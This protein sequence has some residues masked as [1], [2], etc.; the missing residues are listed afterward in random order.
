MAFKRK[1]KREASYEDIE[2]LFRDRRNRKVQGLLSHQS[3]IL[4]RYEKEVIDKP[5]VAIELPTGSGKTLVGLLI[6][7]FRRITRQERILYL[8]PTRQLVRQV[9]EQSDRKYGISAK[10]FI[11]K[12]RDYN[13]VDKS[14][15]E[16]GE[17][18]AVAPYGA[19]FNTNP[20]FKNPQ[21][22]VLDD[23]HASE[24]YI[25]S[26]W[27]LN[28]NRNDNRL[29]FELLQIFN[30]H[31]PDLSLDRFQ[32]DSFDR[33]VEK[34]PTATLI[35]VS[36]EVRDFLNENLTKDNGDLYYCWLFL[37]DH[38]NAC[39]VYVSY[40]EILIRPY[41]PPSLTHQP[42]ANATQRVFMSATLGMGGDLERM[43]GIK[44]FSR[45]PIPDGWD[46]QGIGRRY[47]VFPELS[48]PE[49]EIESLTKSM[50]QQAG[51]ALILVP[52][53]QQIEKYETLFKDISLYKAADIERSK[54]NFVSQDKGV[55]VLANRYD[56]IDFLD[57]DCR[58]L[59]IEG[60]PKAGNLQ[61]L[62]LTT[63]MVAGNLFKDRIRTRIIQAFGRCT[64]SATDYAAI[65]VIGDDFHDWL[66]HPEKRSL[67][68]P[69]LQGEL[70]FGVEQ[71][72]KVS[73][74][75]HIDN[76]NT[77]L[78][79]EDDWDEV[80]V[81]I[82]EYR[83]EVEQQPMPGQDQLLE[84]AALEVDYTYAVWNSDY[85]K[86]L[87]LAQN[88]ASGL[89]GEGLKGL[90]GLWYYLA[91][92]SAE[93]ASRKLG[94]QEVFMQNAADLYRRASLCLPALDWIRPLSARTVD[95]SSVT[96]T[97]DEYLL[98]TNIEH[99]DLFF[100]NKSFASPQ[101]FERVAKFILDGLDTADSDK[102]E[103][104]HRLLGEMLGFE[105]GN[106]D[107]DAAPDPW[108]ISGKRLCLV[109]EDKSDSKPDGAIPVKHTRQAASHP[110]WIK[111][112]IKLSP[113]AEIFV[114]MIT[115]QSKI[116]HEVPTYS[117]DVC[118]WHIDDFREWARHVI[119]VLRN[120][121]S[122][123]TGAGQSEW[124]ELVKE[125]LL[126]HKLDPISIMQ[127]T[128]QN[129]LKDLDFESSNKS[130]SS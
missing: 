111:K 20:F 49:K 127:K 122:K 96:V 117:K 79:H 4:R 113:N 67:F 82:R 102:F 105:S 60:L 77:F 15:Y 70:M 52:R 68:H 36:R 32:N 14:E 98:H 56:G 27:S 57:S 18:I 119:E 126:E 1:K 53:D 7:E 13:T 45:L 62:F 107:A 39:H 99:I 72:K 10:P 108:W 123:F 118:W 37:K 38:L 43:T 11:G 28:I 83:D 23:A 61:E 25:A 93:L 76:L 63:R 30:L 6:A 101:R 8:C 74:E 2:A 17:I 86:A 51:R 29:Y 125:Q 124:R 54:D 69:E 5:D 128:R 50:A 31:D 42:F 48:L 114:T 80:D 41:I 64:R 78:E 71:S 34:I 85:E 104:A 16:T 58:L 73:S 24:N 26:K 95:N 65:V 94:K 19:L 12:V 89:S 3:D 97:E 59:I 92:S 112:H 75:D 22:I 90:R 121:R 100:E 35:E 47:F 87:E 116:H 44:S 130:S 21:L 106:S 46:K 103:E 115:T 109:F 91:A 81:D 129:F 66:V 88:I 9:C 40:Y 120:L 84:K 33:L 110:D 55:L